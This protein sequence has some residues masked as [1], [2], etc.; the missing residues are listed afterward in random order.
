M[1][2]VQAEV[3]G[4]TMGCPHWPGAA[5]G[6]LS[7]A[8]REATW[9]CRWSSQTLSTVLNLTLMSPLPLAPAPGPWD[10]LWAQLSWA[11][12]AVAAPLFQGYLVCRPERR[13]TVCGL[14]LLPFIPG[15][16]QTLAGLGR[17]QS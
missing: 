13:V 4:F 9:P 14:S 3:R 10:W 16:F 2:L 17:F 15:K 11:P 12:T 7:P 5:A 1:V 6:C 8:C